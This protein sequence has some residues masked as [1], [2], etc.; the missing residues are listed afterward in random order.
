M[1]YRHAYHAGSRT[2]V[3]KH[4]VLA[5]ILEHL[6]RKDKPFFVLDTHAG[7]GI[8]DLSSDEA[9]K[10]GEAENGIGRV[11]QYDLPAGAAY[12]QLVRSMNPQSALVRYPGSPAIIQSF[13]R[14]CDRL[15]ACELHPDDVTRL[16]ANF[17]QDKRVSIRKRDGYQAIWAFVPPPE[18]RGLIFIDP[19]FE[20][21]TEFD[22]LA[23]ALIHAQNRWPSG[24]LAAWYPVKSRPAIRG[25]KEVLREAKIRECMSVQLLFCPMDDTTLAGS[26]MILVNPPWRMDK[27]LR[28]LGS[29]I[30]AILQKQNGRTSIE[31][32]TPPE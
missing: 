12:L 16:R 24:I 32:I 28:K 23:R 19:P 8:Y 3:F 21:P 29:E 1:N 11:L 14:D 27:L 26:G 17:R 13:L 15:V 5:Q 22:D 7:L 4:A 25:L 30:L 31:W 10:T 18:R 20:S 6:R 9:C 2:E